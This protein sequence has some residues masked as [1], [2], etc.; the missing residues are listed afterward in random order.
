MQWGP[1]DQS[2]TGKEVDPVK[3][4]ALNKSIEYSREEKKEDSNLQQQEKQST[5]YSS[6]H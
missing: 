6:T 4:I 1:I 2:I 5:G 3:I